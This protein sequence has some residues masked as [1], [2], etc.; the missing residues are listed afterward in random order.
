MLKTLVEEVYSPLP[1]MIY[2]SAVLPP[3]VGEPDDTAKALL[4][5]VKDGEFIATSCVQLWITNGLHRFRELTNLAEIN[6]DPRQVVFKRCLETLSFAHSG[7]PLAQSSSFN[8]G[9]SK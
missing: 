2:I 5:G 6:P 7:T 8:R 1:S 4:G 3:G 9:S